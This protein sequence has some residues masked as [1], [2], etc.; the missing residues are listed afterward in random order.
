MGT[1][2]ANCKKETISTKWTLLSSYNAKVHSK[3]KEE[4]LKESIICSTFLT[5]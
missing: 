1:Y 4:D 2:A 3:D 5:T